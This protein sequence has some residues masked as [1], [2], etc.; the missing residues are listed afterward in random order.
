VSQTTAVFASAVTYLPP[1]VALSLGHFLAHESLL[2]SEIVAVFVSSCGVALASGDSA[3][4]SLASNDE[5][6]VTA[7]AK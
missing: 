3:G 2:P 4:S 5:A 7:S 1:L 6:T